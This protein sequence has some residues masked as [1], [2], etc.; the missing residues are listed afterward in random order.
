[1][2]EHLLSL[3]SHL[4]LTSVALSLAR[5]WETVC[6][7]ISIF[8]I[9]N[10]DDDDYWGCVYYPFLLTHQWSIDKAAYGLEKRPS[11]KLKE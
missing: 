8:L 2:K 3:V 4:T 10:D 7:G 9:N 1:M 5:L 11:G 6:G